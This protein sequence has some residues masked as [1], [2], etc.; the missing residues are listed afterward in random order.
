MCESERK[1][2]LRQEEEL[3]IGQFSRAPE[4]VLA[5][6]HPTIAQC[7]TR[8]PT[9]TAVAQQHSILVSYHHGCHIPLYPLP[10]NSLLQR[11]THLKSFI[12]GFVHVQYARRPRPPRRTYKIDRF[13]PSWHLFMTACLHCLLL[14]AVLLLHNLVARCG[15]AVDGSRLSGRCCDENKQWADFLRKVGV[16]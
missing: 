9:S 13:W 12:Q 11:A 5:A 8:I 2:L 15:T 7:C 10:H 4:N 16:K 6:G 1:M 14:P 3:G